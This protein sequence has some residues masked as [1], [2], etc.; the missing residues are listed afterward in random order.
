MANSGENDDLGDAY[1]DEDSEQEYD[2]IEHRLSDREEKVYNPFTDSQSDEISRT[3]R[4][5]SVPAPN[6][7]PSRESF[8]ADEERGA[9]NRSS[10]PASQLLGNDSRE[11]DRFGV[12][13]IVT[14][15][16]KR[17]ESS[18]S[19]ID[20]EEKD[21]TLEYS[22]SIRDNDDSMNLNWDNLW[23]KLSEDK[24]LGRELCDRVDWN[25]LSADQSP[26]PSD[27]VY[28]PQLLER[29]VTVMNRPTNT[30]INDS[31]RPILPPMLMIEAMKNLLRD[32]FSSLPQFVMLSEEDL[33]GLATSMVSTIKEDDK[34]HTSICYRMLRYFHSVYGGDLWPKTL[35]PLILWLDPSW[36]DPPVKSTS[37]I[38]GKIHKKKMKKGSYNCS[39]CKKPKVTYT[40][41]GV[42]IPH[43]TCPKHQ[44]TDM[45]LE[46]ELG[47]SNVDIDRILTDTPKKYPVRYA[48]NVPIFALS[49]ACYN[50]DG[51]SFEKDQK[52]AAIIHRNYTSN[53]SSP[54]GNRFPC[55]DASSLQFPT[56][57]KE[58]SAQQ[59]VRLIFLCLLDAIDLS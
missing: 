42:R 15:K 50:E 35:F 9:R 25:G 4:V 44:G 33:E 36:L 59:E 41:D 28:V 39:F 58:S 2:R 56:E 30:V 32:K 7:S 19:L 6:L 1:L 10:A 37:A 14:N 23:Q 13:T 18:L 54:I 34:N 11:G 57:R 48:Q 47:G 16:R 22:A 38:K 8:P 53:S 29:N 51:S 20:V 49:V 12:N 31:K 21:E 24:V 5:S 27:P 26:A 52:H 17:Q 43:G 3:T 55:D 40:E 46:K 45:G